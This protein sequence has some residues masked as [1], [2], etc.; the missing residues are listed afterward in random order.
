VPFFQPHRTALPF[1]ILLL[2][3]SILAAPN[4]WTALLAAILMFLIL[5]IKDLVLVNRATASEMLVLT[6]IFLLALIFFGRFES[7]AQ[8]GFLPSLMGASLA[9]WLLLDHLF[10]YFLPDNSSRQARL[11]GSGIAALLSGEWLWLVSFLPMNKFLQTAFYLVSLVVL[12]EA[13]IDY[14]R[15]EMDNRRALAYFSV[16]FALSVVILVANPWSIWAR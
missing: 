4:L 1:F 3:L 7:P 15:G 9:V 14:W 5:G 13:L 10:F 6:M 8:P 16:W 11:L 12:V 2:T